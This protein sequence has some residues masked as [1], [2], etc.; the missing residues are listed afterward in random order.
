MNI[1]LALRYIVWVNLYNTHRIPSN[2]LEI[3]GHY[4]GKRIIRNGSGAFSALE[5]KGNQVRC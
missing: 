2:L 5:N 4:E 1:K 3:Y